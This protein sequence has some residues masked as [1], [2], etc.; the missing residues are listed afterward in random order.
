[1][2]FIHATAYEVQT[3]INL[4]LQM[5]NWVRERLNNLPTVTQLES[6]DPDLKAL[7]IQ[8]QCSQ[9]LSWLPLCTWNTVEWQNHTTGSTKRSRRTEGLDSTWS[10]GKAKQTKFWWISR[11]SDIAKDKRLD[12]HS[13]TRSI[14]FQGSVFRHDGTPSRVLGQGVEGTTVGPVD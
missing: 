4:I 3:I 7:W 5:R 11:G 6:T 12:V 1:M 9:P 10:S 2:S 13:N 8:T 14:M